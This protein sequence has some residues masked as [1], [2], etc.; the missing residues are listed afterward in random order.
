[1]LIIVIRQR[2]LYLLMSLMNESSQILFRGIKA[3]KE[4]T[5]APIPI[6]P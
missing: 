2:Y 1:M 3:L 4:M 6:N 5:L